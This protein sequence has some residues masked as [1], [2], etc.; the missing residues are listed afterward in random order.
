MSKKQAYEEKF[1]AQLNELDAKIDVLKAKAE[2]AK[3][4]AKADYYET[5][6]D[7]VKKRTEAQNKLNAMQK[8][9]DEA[10]ED[11]KQ[12]VEESWNVLSAAVKSAAS[13]FQ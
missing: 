2:G 4:S 7:L 3:A 1:K 11:M 12:G 9:G 13:R 5:I 10:W 8:A 6:E